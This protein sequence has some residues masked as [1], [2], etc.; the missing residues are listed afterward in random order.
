VEVA[1]SQLERGDYI[2]PELYGAQE[3]KQIEWARHPKT[4]KKTKERRTLLTTSIK[5]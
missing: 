5:H 4:M 2:H 3:E 1:K